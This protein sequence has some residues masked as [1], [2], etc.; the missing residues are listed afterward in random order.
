MKFLLTF[1]EI[2][3]TCEGEY[4]PGTPGKVS[5]PPEDCIPEEL[6]YFESGTVTF[7]GGHGPIESFEVFSNDFLLALDDAAQ[8][9]A[10]EVFAAEKGKNHE[11]S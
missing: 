10:D 2:D 4:F 7:N 1:R 3:F 6:A 11:T 5:G 8:T 9:R